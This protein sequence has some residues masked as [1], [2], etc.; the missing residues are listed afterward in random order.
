VVGRF[1]AWF[2]VP[3][4]PPSDAPRKTSGDRDEGWMRSMRG[5]SRAGS[6]TLAA[7]AAA[8]FTALNLY[9]CG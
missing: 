5:D 9:G 7:S 3:P 8:S 2:L 1:Q 6:L 4:R